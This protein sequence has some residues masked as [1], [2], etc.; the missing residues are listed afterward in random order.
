M[1]STIIKGN[2]LG[3]VGR[4]LKDAEDLE[5]LY[6]LDMMKGMVEKEIAITFTEINATGLDSNDLQKLETFC[7]S[8]ERQY[9]LKMKEMDKNELLQRYHGPRAPLIEINVGLWD[10]AVHSDEKKLFDCW[11]DRCVC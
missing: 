8:K 3:Y 11:Q 2:I 5:E 10:N 9:R 4:E 7:K 6:L 1:D